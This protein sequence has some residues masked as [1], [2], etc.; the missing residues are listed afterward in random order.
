MVKEIEGAEK[1][2]ARSGSLLDKPSFREKN[3][4]HVVAGAEARLSQH[5]VRLQ[6]LQDRF[7]TLQE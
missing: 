2:I 1:S 5:K 3:P 4:Q 7:D 6:K